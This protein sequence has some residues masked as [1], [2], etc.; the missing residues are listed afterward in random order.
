MASCPWLCAS[1]SCS[2]SQVSCCALAPPPNLTKRLAGPSSPSGL[3]FSCVSCLELSSL[4]SGPASGCKE[5]RQ[6]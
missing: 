1:A 6:A 5:H 2:A 4:L 3:F